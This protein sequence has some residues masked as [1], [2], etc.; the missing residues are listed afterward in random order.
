MPISW[1]IWSI[2]RL[3]RDSGKLIAFFV[4]LKTTFDSVDREMLVRS[5][6]ER[7]VRERLVRRCED[8][9]RETKCRIRQR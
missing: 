1:I 9:F 2:D 5:L 7:G 8:L 3:N 4:N 6:R